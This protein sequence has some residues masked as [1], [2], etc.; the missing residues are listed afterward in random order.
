[1][2]VILICFLLFFL[3]SAKVKEETFDAH[4]AWQYIKDLASESMFPKPKIF[5]DGF[6]KATGRKQ[7]VE[8]FIFSD[9]DVFIS[10]I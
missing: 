6:F 2:R 4:S 8:P 9:T 3:L 10:L 5:F 1:M 7:R